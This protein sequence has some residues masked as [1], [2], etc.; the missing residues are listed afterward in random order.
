[1]VVFYTIFYC[2]QMF[3]TYLNTFIDEVLFSCVNGPTKLFMEKKKT[4]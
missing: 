1:M 2:S 4:I 3:G